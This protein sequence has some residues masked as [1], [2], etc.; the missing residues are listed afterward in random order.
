MAYDRGRE[1]GPRYWQK[2]RR[3]G[4]RATSALWVFYARA[5]ALGLLLILHQHFAQEYF[6]RGKNYKAL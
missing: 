5:V 2:N 6:E 4:A 3:E 1:I